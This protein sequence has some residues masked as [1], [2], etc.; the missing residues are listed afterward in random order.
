MVKEQERSDRWLEA[1]I[2]VVGCALIEPELAPRI[3]AESDAG[4]YTGDYRAVYCAM[5]ELLA[6]NKPIDPVIVRAHIGGNIAP[7]LMDAMRQTPTT[8]N[9]DY[10]L[11]ACKEQARLAGIRSMAASLLDAATLDE[12]KDLVDKAH[13]L[14]VER[15]H[16]RAVTM[17]EGLQTFFDEHQAGKKEYLDWGIAALND[18]LYVDRGDFVIMG[19]Y[20]SGGKSALMLQMAW[21]MAKKQRV[22]I[23]SFET[24]APKLFDRL[25]SHVTGVPLASIKRS[26]M[27][28]EDWQRV[29]VSIKTICDSQLEIIEAA[30][31]SASDV[32]SLT[33]SRRYTVIFLDYLQLIRG[34]VSRGGNRTEEVTRISMALHTMA[35]R[36]GIIVIA[37]SQL[38]RPPKA[39]PRKQKH[40]TGSDD[41]DSEDYST[42]PAPGL[43]DLRESGQLEQDADVV[44][45]L[46]RLYPGTKNETRR[47]RIAKNKEG[48]LG[49]FN[50]NFDGAT[51]TFSRSTHEEI[52]RYAADARRDAKLGAL[53]NPTPDNPFI[54]QKIPLE[55][56]KNEDEG[57]NKK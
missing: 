14:T 52:A 43:S 21:H 19:G 28:L 38:T 1:Q 45:F 54:Q 47:L 8:V 20:P 9:F 35:Q 49:G 41:P 6:E 27:R 34:D 10:Y 22:G 4:D 12:A 40:F 32:L 30:G 36:H 31:M 48:R 29:N 7:V 18:N 44:M 15:S 51:Q 13:A 16:V 2:A 25:I 24:S 3:I 11:T 37:L 53:K 55:E 56:K 26:D 50:F 23:F 46:Y 42:V 39:Q 5:Q 33:V 17:E 57:K